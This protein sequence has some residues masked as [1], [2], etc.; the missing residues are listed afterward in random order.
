MKLNQQRD[1]VPK[2][3]I[4]YT[5]LN[6]ASTIGMFLFCVDHFS[7]LPVGINQIYLEVYDECNFSVDE[8]IAHATISIPEEIFKG[9]T[10]EEWYNLNGKQGDGKEGQILLV[11]SFMVCK[12]T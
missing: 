2:A 7:F 11:F 10:V 5:I 12:H 1:L 3:K 4:P 8:L 9:E 6:N